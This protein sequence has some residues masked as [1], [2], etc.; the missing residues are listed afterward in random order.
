V[1]VT[2]F[3]LSWTSAA[4][5]ALTWDG[6]SADCNWTIFADGRIVGTVYGSGTLTHTLSLSQRES[7]TISIVQHAGDVIVQSAPESAKLLQPVVRWLPVTY[8]AEYLIYE[9][10]ED[11]VEYFMRR[12]VA[13]SDT[14]LYT[15]QYPVD[16]FYEGLG[17]IRIRVYAKGS[18]GLCSTPSVVVGLLSGYPP[19][20]VTLA[21]EE[22]SAG[23]ELVI[24]S[25]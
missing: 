3:T 15:W 10:D 13:N 12:V 25:A 16:I 5:A 17:H 1:L 23:L 24:G 22:S 2:D 21:V 4:R 9:L 18:W 8:A 19:R 20:A 7:Y 6:G 14:E 11:G